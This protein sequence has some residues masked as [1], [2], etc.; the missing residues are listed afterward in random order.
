MI[1]EVVNEIYKRLVHNPDAPLLSTA[2]QLEVL[3]AAKLCRGVDYVC[4]WQTKFGIDTATQIVTRANWLFILC[5][6]SCYSQTFRGNEIAYPRFSMEFENVP[7]PRRFVEKTDPS[8]MDTVPTRLTIGCQGNDAAIGNFP[9]YHFEE[10]KN[11]I[12]LLKERTVITTRI[13][14]YTQLNGFIWQPCRG[15]ILYSGLEI[16]RECFE[17]V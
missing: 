1:R 17:R 4:N 10:P 9:N 12:H 7:F 11:V 14:P 15:Q 13:L 16:S 8:L 5:G 6:V 2:Q 3:T